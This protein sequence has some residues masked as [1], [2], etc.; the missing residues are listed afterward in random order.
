FRKHVLVIITPW[1]DKT[2]QLIKKVSTKD[3]PKAIIQRIADDLLAAC[4]DLQLID[5]Y[6]VYQHLMA[7]WAE[8]MQDDAY[9]IT[10]EGWSAGNQVGRLQKE[11]KSKKKDIEGLAG[12]E[13]RLIPIA[14]L[15]S[16]YYAGRQKQLDE[17]NT[18]LEQIAV[19]MDEL[20]DEHG[21]EEGLLAEVIEN[22]KISKGSVQKRIKEVQ[23]DADF[24][25]ELE[26]LKE[27]SALFE[28]EAKTKAKIKEAEKDLERKVLAQYKALSLEE[29]KTLVVERKWM[30]AL[31]AAVMGEVDR[32]SQM[33]TGRVNQLARRYALPLPAI[34]DNVDD[35]SARVDAHLKT[36]GFVW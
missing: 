13:G 21:A 18:K 31:A 7:Y 3:H 6:D 10:V 1:R 20:K 25:D 14:L 8:T 33:L 30:D 36:M 32:L 17:L 4:S 2:T 24:A 23:G 5:K 28:E 26:V 27:Y 34:M 22:D 29:I 15:I 19:Q 11:S 35:L 16:T 9:I 12:L